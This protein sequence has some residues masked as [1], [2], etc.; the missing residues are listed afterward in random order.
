VAVGK[1]LFLDQRLSADGTISCATCH[2]PDRSF[3]DG[4][5][6]AVGIGRRIGTRNAP[7]LYNV[8]FATTLFWDG[9]ISGL[10]AQ[11]KLPL[12]NL[13]E[14]GL[15][16]ESD[17]L[18]RI[19]SDR[20]YRQE[21]GRLSLGPLSIA[22][23]TN[24]LAAYERTLLAGNSP[25]DRYQYAGDR[26]AM[27][28]SA[29]RGLKLFRG[30]AGCASCH[31][32]DQSFALLS[33][34]QFHPSPA[35][36][37]PEVNRQLVELTQRVATVKSRGRIDELNSLIVEDPGVAALGRFVVTL[38]PAD[39]GL[40]RTPSLRNVTETGPYLHDGQL[41][42]LEDVVEAELYSRGSDIRYPIVV[43]A[44]EMADLLAFLSALRSAKSS[45]YP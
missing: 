45:V 9:R 39:I 34:G 26:H 24:A 25:F 43:T 40:F 31:T 28:D 36:I 4:V 17:L 33:D 3:T 42:K 38:N 6:L 27:T 15:A 19:T 44:S 23:V 30:R 11:A 35:G 18:S 16:S 37:P 10:E 1:E 21:F 29:I 8:R 41:T 2:R 13:Y 20:H 14:H 5:A 7:S 22:L 32:I 12:L